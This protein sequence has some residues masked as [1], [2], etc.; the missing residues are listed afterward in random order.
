MKT[1]L[2]LALL[3]LVTVCLPLAAAEPRTAD[4]ILK[5]YDAIKM[6]ALDPSKTRDQDYIRKYITDRNVVMEKQGALAEELYKAHPD[7]PKA[8]QLMGLRLMQKLSGAEYAN[9]TGEAEEFVKA[10]PKSELSPNLLAMVAMRTDNRD[11][12]LDLYRRIVADYPD[13]QAALAAKGQLRQIEDIGKPFDLAFTDAI[14]EKPVSMKGLHGK[15]V[16]VDFW[17]T[18]CGP[19]VAEM[20]NMKQLYAKYK[21]KGVEFIGVSLDQPGE[22]LEKLKKFVEDK[23]IEWPQ[24]Y[25]GNGWQSDFSSSWGITGIPCLFVV[26]ADGNLYSAEARG[27]LEDLIPELI[28]K[29][30]G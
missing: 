15:V 5:D 10:H 17:A 18:W 28:K 9:A 22:G 25:Q 16:V 11:K 29:R 1:A 20:P 24:Y 27:K 3:L 19:C 8:P 14:T 26:D 13:S 2:Q 6:P 23:G 7:H 30:D 21:D 12:E 4:E